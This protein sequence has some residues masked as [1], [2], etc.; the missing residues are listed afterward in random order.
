MH[1]R[2]E[3]REAIRARLAQVTGTKNVAQYPEG[4]DYT[5]EEG[6]EG[7]IEP[8]LQNLYWTAADDRVHKSRSVEVTPDELPMLLV[9]A[10]D[11]QVELVNKTHFEGGYRRTLTLHVEGLVE[12]LDDVEDDLDRMALGIEGALDGLVIEGTESAHLM[13]RSTDIDVD[14]EGELP[15]GAIRLTYEVIYNS[16]RLGVDL[17]LWDR[18]YPNNCPA[19]QITKVIIRSHIP[20]GSVDYSTMEVDL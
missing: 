15:L 5:L 9:S 8:I 3:I 19:P 7:Y 2:Q 14:R 4:Y 12:A 6:D 10:K 16:H 1:P 18:D 13:L 17:G 11:E 20:E